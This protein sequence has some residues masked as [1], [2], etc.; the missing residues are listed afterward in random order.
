LTF[1][2]ERSSKKS[3]LE[4]VRSKFMNFQNPNILM[5]E[6][7]KK[8]FPFKISALPFTRSEFG[9]FLPVFLIFAKFSKSEHTNFQTNQIF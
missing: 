5:F 1:F 2:K 4:K 6:M 9:R 3:I 8:V 7:V